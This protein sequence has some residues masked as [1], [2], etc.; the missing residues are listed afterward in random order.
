MVQ[1]GTWL[2]A[3]LATGAKIGLV[4]CDPAMFDGQEV[5][6]RRLESDRSI[7]LA[8]A[9]DELDRHVLSIN[10]IGRHLV[11]NVR[12]GLEKVAIGPARAL[13]TAPDGAEAGEDSTASSA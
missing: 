2:G 9:G 13:L 8:N 1:T 3:R 5:G 10:H 6:K 7:G 4:P 12:S 11:L